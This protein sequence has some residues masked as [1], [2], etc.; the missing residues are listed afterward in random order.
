MNNE[1]RLLQWCHRHEA[2]VR[3]K[4]P[5]S[6]E[7]KIRGVRKVYAYCLADAAHAIDDILAARDLSMGIHTPRLSDDP[8]DRDSVAPQELPRGV[9][10]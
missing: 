7:V 9:Q 10:P 8:F 2:T 5:N 4:N 1:H 3:F 6:V